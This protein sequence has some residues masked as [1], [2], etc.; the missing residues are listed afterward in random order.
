MLVTNEMI[1][2]IHADVRAADAAL[3]AHRAIP[4][5]LPLSQVQDS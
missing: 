2:T 4:A 3:A 1:D 5:R